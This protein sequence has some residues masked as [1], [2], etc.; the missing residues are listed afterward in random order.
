MF[1]LAHLDPVVSDYVGDSDELHVL[2]FRNSFSN[3][4][5]DNAETIDSNPS[6]SLGQSSSLDDPEQGH[7]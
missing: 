7:F 5:P 3:T 2:L 4:F 1:L 6:R